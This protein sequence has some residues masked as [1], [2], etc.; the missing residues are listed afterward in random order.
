MSKKRG[1]STGSGPAGKYGIAEWF[2]EPYLAMSAA[3]RRRA[4]TFAEDPRVAPI[5]P[6][7]DDGSRCGK[8]GGVC[9]I[10]K[11]RLADEEVK[12]A[13]SD[14]DSISITCPERFKE[15]AEVY[16]WI[17]QTLLGDGDYQILGEIG[18][19]QRLGKD[20][21]AV[22]DDE[23]G[24]IDN[25]L[26]RSVGSRLEWCAVE[27][28]AVY[29][30]GRGME[31]DF[32]LMRAAKGEAIVPAVTR[33]PDFRSSGPKRLMPQLQTKVPTLRRWGIKTAVVIDQSFY[34]SLGPMKLVDD[35]SSADIAWFVVSVD[36]TT[37]PHRLVQ[38]QLC[39]TTLD[40]AVAGL[41]A[42]KPLTKEQFESK[43]KERL[44]KK[45]RE[46]KRDL[47]R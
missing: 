45:A 33:R 26:A 22:E 19:L 1:K 44:L 35:V 14:P 7:R 23:V 6:F 41:T 27:T 20:G 4:L 17:A 31:S 32:E 37:N 15:R 13:S 34:E 29:F 5:C 25:I 11:Y 38:T 9:S 46:P 3:G 39:Y 8:S 47:S 42:G 21:V 43:I 24:R 10:R 36:P 12:A 28:Q 2:G 40:E 18:F 30:S 16:R